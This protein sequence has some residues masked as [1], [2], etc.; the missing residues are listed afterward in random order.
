MSNNLEMMSSLSSSQSE[1]SSFKDFNQALPIFPFYQPQC[2]E[3]FSILISHYHTFNGE[4]LNRFN[5]FNKRILYPSQLF[6]I[7][8]RF[9]EYLQPLSVSQSLVWSG[10]PSLASG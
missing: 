2:K 3:H 1:T 8:T 7:L 9:E 10:L 5:Y 4:F 6:D